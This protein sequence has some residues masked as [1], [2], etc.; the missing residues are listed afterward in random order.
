MMAG[1][2]GPPDG[3]AADAS[4]RSCSASTS[5]WSSRVADP[6]RR[7]RLA[8]GLP[9]ALHRRRPLAPGARQRLDPGRARRGPEPQLT[10]ETSWADWVAAGKP[11]ANPLK[12]VLQRRIRPRGSIRELARMRKVFR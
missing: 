4:T 7:Q 11:D 5:T 8:A 10:L 12:M 6:Q 1:I 2:L 9:V 3:P